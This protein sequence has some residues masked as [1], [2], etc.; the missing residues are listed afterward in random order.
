MLITDGMCVE[1]AHKQAFP[2]TDKD[3]EQT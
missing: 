3:H 2:E 1:Q